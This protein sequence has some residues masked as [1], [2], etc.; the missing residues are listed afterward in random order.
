MARTSLTTQP[1]VQT[2]L[3]PTLAEPTVDG[4]VIDCG[5]VALYV[6]NTTGAAV[7]V[8]VVSTAT[9]DG[10][11]VADLAVSVPAGAVALIGPLPSRTFGQDSASPDAGRA[12][13]N[14]SAQTGVN[15]A[16]VSL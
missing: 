9:L 14:Y 6:D 15:R 10:L 13:V 7:T 11:D 2:G 4:D 5:R 16:V 3:V 8:T 12:Y 1:I